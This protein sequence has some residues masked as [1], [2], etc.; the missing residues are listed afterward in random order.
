MKRQVHI[1]LW[2][3]I[4]SFESWKQPGV[5][6]WNTLQ[7]NCT[8]CSNSLTISLTGNSDVTLACDSTIS[9]LEAILM[10]WGI[11]S[12]IITSTL[13]CLD[14]FHLHFNTIQHTFLQQESLTY[15]FIISKTGV[16]NM[17]CWTSREA[18]NVVVWQTS[19]NIHI[20]V[21]LRIHTGYGGWVRPLSVNPSTTATHPITAA[22]MDP[23]WEKPGSLDPVYG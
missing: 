2:G 5:E 7:S 12:L 10:C 14:I 13:S 8:C 6:C 22:R 1:S 4:Y 15:L 17:V 9:L 11:T 16:P 18:G 3:F 21:L 23:A 20:R 19:P